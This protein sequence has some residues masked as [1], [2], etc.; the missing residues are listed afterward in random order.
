MRQRTF[1]PSSPLSTF[2]FGR[3]F[4]QCLRATDGRGRQCAQVPALL[5]RT[6]QL[7]GLQRSHPAS[8]L[9]G[10][11]QNDDNI[12]RW[13]EQL[14]ST[15]SVQAGVRSSKSAAGRKA[16]ARPNLLWDRTCSV[17]RRPVLREQHGAKKECSWKKI[18]FLDGERKSNMGEV[19]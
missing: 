12:V 7:G 11:G 14:N 2:N 1:V 17:V 5:D 18:C 9:V 13:Q 4:G 6:G 3:G 8:A 15:Q 19:F 10:R 16:V